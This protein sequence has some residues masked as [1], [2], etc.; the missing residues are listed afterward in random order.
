[1]TNVKNPLDPDPKG[2]APIIKCFNGASSA[3]QEKLSRVS[4]TP[5]CNGAADNT[6][7]VEFINHVFSIYDKET[8]AL[9]GARVS[10]TQFWQAA[11]IQSPGNI[12]D[13]RIVFI[14]DAGRY[15]QWLAVQIQIGYLVYIATTDPHDQLTD[16]RLG[17][18][19]A[20]V[21]ALPGNDFTMLGYDANGIYIGVNSSEGSGSGRSP[22]IVVIP[23]S[24][25]LAYPPQVGPDAIKIIGPLP[26]GTYGDSL[27]PIIDQSGKGWPYETAIGVNNFSKRHLTF[28][29]ISPKFRDILSHGRIEVEPFEPITTAYRVKQPFSDNSNVI[30]DNDSIVSAPTSDGF[31]IWL[32]HTVFKPNIPPGVN[33]LAVRWYRLYI[34]PVTRQPGLAAWGEIFNPHYDYFNPSILSFGKD[35]YTIVSLS[36]SGDY[37]T[38]RNPGDPACGNIGAYAALVR[39]TESGATTEIVPLRGGQADNYIPKQAQRWGDYSTICRDPNPRNAR[40]AWIINQYVLQGGASVSQWCDVIASIDLP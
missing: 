5:D 26:E 13:P 3:D 8:G 2:V 29:L 22:Q 36:R 38:P 37:S 18:W 34:D 6:Y 12:V 4:F 19:K 28:S 16:P 15:G 21:F 35:D 24:N 31:N 7:F 27:Y 11:G 23:R 10:G 9:I 30:F 40:R 33:S 14:P 25:A 39:E 20:S 17:K 32:A 1:M